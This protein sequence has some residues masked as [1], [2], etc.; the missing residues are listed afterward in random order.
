MKKAHIRRM[1]AAEMRMIRMMLGKMLHDGIPN[2]MLRDTVEQEW[3][4]LRIIWERPD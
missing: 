1:Q 2:S 3:R 4:T